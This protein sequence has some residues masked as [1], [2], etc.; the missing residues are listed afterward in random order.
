MKK[1]IIY[2]LVFQLL[3][4]FVNCTKNSTTTGPGGS[5][6]TNISIIY[7]NGGEIFYAND[8][9]LISWSLSDNSEIKIDLLNN[10]QEKNFIITDNRV[11]S[12]N[13]EEVYSYDISYSID[14]GVTWVEI[15]SNATK[16][17]YRWK[18]PSIST[19]NCLVKIA[20]HSNS[21][22]YDIS[23]SVFTLIDSVKR[24]NVLSPNGGESWVIGDTQIILWE[25]NKIN[26]FS[27]VYSTDNGNYW[28][29]IGNSISDSFIWEIPDIL[30]DS[31]VIKINDFDDSTIYDICDSLFSISNYRINL[32][33]P[34]GGQILV[35]GEQYNIIWS[36]NYFT[37]SF[38]IYF[39]SDEGTSWENVVY[40]IISPYI[41]NIP[42]IRSENCLIKI[43]DHN[44]PVI[45]DES[46]YP[47]ITTGKPVVEIIAP[48]SST[49][50]QKF[51]CPSDTLF[52]AKGDTPIVFTQTYTTPL[53]DGLKVWI[54]FSD[55][56]NYPGNSPVQYKYKID[57][58]Q[59]SIGSLD[60]IY[61]IL[62]QMTDGYHYFYLQGTNRANIESNL[63]SLLFKSVNTNFSQR[64]IIVSFA[65]YI[66]A[67][68]YTQWYQNFFQIL[69]PMTTIRFVNRGPNDP[70]LTPED[71]GGA[72][73]YILLRDDISSSN[74]GFIKDSLTL[75][76]YA[77]MGGHIWTFGLNIINPQTDTSG[78]AGLLYRDI[79]GIEY[80]DNCMAVS[81]FDGAYV[82]SEGITFGLP[83]DT[84]FVYPNHTFPPNHTSLKYAECFTPSSIYSTELY[85]WIGQSPWNDSTVAFIYDNPTLQIKSA[86][87]G[88]SGYSMNWDETSYEPLLSIYNTIFLWFGL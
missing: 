46:N 58:N 7:P 6:N 55:T 17:N 18:I 63:D 54:N 14:S 20:D 82:S 23:D 64:D 68:L 29:N 15:I 76:Q 25:S 34:N 60:S 43:V 5:S 56:L 85:K 51:Y 9:V 80:Y 30:S 8:S 72:A 1:I 84:L 73:I 47:F 28:Y 78:I 67:N 26:N 27:I 88:F 61:T 37:N 33:S 65:S 77:A 71:L 45:F 62:D 48:D 12:S 52:W 36:E 13:S 44:N 24:I 83:Q 87:F 31:C 22:N 16:K 69:R 10:P 2:F 21:D 41:W 50:L 49:G 3:F 39:S 75:Y 86:V 35:S 81:G 53:W 79:L 70:I 11:D 19:I 66:S 40:D 38:D 74:P 42:I 57:D 32:I 59:W 4:V